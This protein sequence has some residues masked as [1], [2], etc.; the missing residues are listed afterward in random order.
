M[1]AEACLRVIRTFHGTLSIPAKFQ[2]LPLY[3]YCIENPFRRIGSEL[4]ERFDHP[5]RN[6]K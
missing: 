3:P 5:L 4:L 6:L 2:I 1:I